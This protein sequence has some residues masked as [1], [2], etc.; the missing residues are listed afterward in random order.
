MKRT[1]LVTGGAGFL[2][3][4]LSRSLI[5]DGYY[6]IIVDNLS[7]GSLDNISGLE[8]GSYEFVCWDVINPFT[9]LDRWIDTGGIDQIFSL[10]SP[11]SPPTYQIDKVGTFKTNI[12][13]AINVLEAAKKFGAKVFSVPS[14]L[15][16][17]I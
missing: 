13:G 11:A 7:T 4:H 5:N 9:F 16:E 3:S 10:A 14:S 8:P 1:A 12:I 15:N 17:A 6:V 2:G